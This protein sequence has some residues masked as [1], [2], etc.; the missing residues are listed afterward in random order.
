MIMKDITTQLD[1]ILKDAEYSVCNNKISL[2]IYD[3]DGFD[4]DYCEIEREFEDAEA[5]EQVLE[6]LEENAD[7]EEGDFYTYYHFGDIVVEVGYTSFDI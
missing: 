4:D 7:Y 5:V 2:T 3:F 6:W 1:R